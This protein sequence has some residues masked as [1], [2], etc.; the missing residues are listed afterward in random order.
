VLDLNPLKIVCLLAAAGVHAAAFQWVNPK[1]L[2]VNLPGP[3]AITWVHPATSHDTQ[4]AIAVHK[5]TRQFAVRGRAQATAMLAIEENSSATSTTELPPEPVVSGSANRRDIAVLL[6]N[7]Q[8]SVS[9]TL[10]LTELE[11]QQQQWLALE[12]SIQGAEPMQL[13]SKGLIHQGTLAVEAASPR[14]WSLFASV[15]Q[16][17]RARPQGAMAT[18]RIEVADAQGNSTALVNLGPQMLDLPSGQYQ[19]L[20]F[21]LADDPA[22]EPVLWLAQAFNYLVLQQRFDHLGQ[23]WT[24]TI[25]NPRLL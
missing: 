13:R 18:S 1:H 19:V 25:P 23:R 17:L 7:Q 10:S 6:S 16:A 22:Q 24:L 12:L 9:G 14:H 5:P 21:A 8:G 20:V 3:L 15:A 4:A 2:A 11:Q